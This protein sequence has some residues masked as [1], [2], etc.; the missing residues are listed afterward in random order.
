MLFA[1]MGVSLGTLAGVATA[2]VS[3][4]MASAA[5]VTDSNSAPV[6]MAALA[7]PTAPAPAAS[8]SSASN[9]ASTQPAAVEP[10]T[11]DPVEVEPVAVDPQVHRAI[12]VE[13]APAAEG[14]RAKT[15]SVDKTSTPE[16]DP[17]ETQ[18]AKHLAHPV[19]RPLRTEVAAAPEVQPEQIE[20]VIDQPAPVEEA[21]SSTFYSEGD[22]TVENYDAALGTI[23][24]TDGRTFE[25]GETVTTG[26]T[27]AWDQYRANVH[28]RCE[29][30]GSCVL[31]RE[32]AVT[33]NSK[34]I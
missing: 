23:E 34:Q 32:G 16:T 2:F 28:Y 33:V 21:K 17:A 8:T 25:L 15:P 26:N 31:Q 20:M 29:Q 6:Q 13:D 3:V 22:I 14:A 18:P 30:G 24:T 1:A 7:A 10:A 9:Q 4:P 5:A 27:V 11:A 19:T 12:K